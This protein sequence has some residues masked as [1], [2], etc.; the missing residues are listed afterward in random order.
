MNVIDQ[1]DDEWRVLVHSRELRRSLRSWAREDRALAFSSPARLVAEV[2]RRDRHPR[3]A[4][5]VLAALARRAPTDDLAARTLLQ[6]LLPGCKAMVRRYHFGEPDERAG[7]VVSAAWD[8]IRT[9]P[10]DRRPAK[11]AANVLLDVRQRLLRGLHR[12]E[13]RDMAL[14]DLPESTLPTPEGSQDPG[15]ESV[16]MLGWAVRQG[17]LDREAAHLIVLTRLG[18]FEVNELAARQGTK[19]QTLRRRRLRAEERLRRAVAV[20]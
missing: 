7:F 14:E 12:P 19:P 13:A 6:L 10:F 9:Y 16:A 2:E 1:L 5:V 18:G 3:H 8:R 20:T 15:A 11:I 4:D 17:H